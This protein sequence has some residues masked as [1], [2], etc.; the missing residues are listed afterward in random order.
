MTEVRETAARFMKAFNAHDEDAM[1]G[2]THPNATFS[3]P[4][5]V[6]LRGVEATGYAMQWL[7][8]CPDGKLT[9]RNQLISGP[10]V[11]EEV[12][13]E[14]THRGPLASAVVGLVPATGRRIAIKAVLITRFESDLALEAR[15]CFDQVELL[16]Q[17]GVMP[18]LAAAA[19]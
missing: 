17:L 10:W 5:D 4:G 8:A 12:T 18:A 1:R 15:I 19:V 6:H 2:L 3:A 7:T 16:T 13:F 9:V 14:G 11:V